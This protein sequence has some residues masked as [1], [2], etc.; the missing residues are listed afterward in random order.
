MSPVLFNQIMHFLSRH[1]EVLPLEEICFNRPETKKP[2]VAITFDDGYRDYLDYALPT[3]KKYGFHSSMFVVTDCV[4]N[5]T[6]TWTYVMD[7]V[8]F[9]TK[10]LEIPR[11]NYG[12]GYEAFELFKWRNKEEQLAYCRKFKQALKKMD[13]AEREKII[14]YFRECFD[15]AAVPG[16]IMMSWDDLR[17]LKNEPVEIGS[18]SISHPPLATIENETLLEHEIRK[19]G[20]IIQSQLG[21]FPV[22]ISYPVGSY[23]RR[24][25]ETAKRSGYKIGLALRQKKFNPDKDDLFEVPRLELYNDSFFR[26]V[27][28]LYGIETAIKSLIRR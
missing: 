19:S 11:R 20:E 28:K 12:K 6:P 4:D 15:D 8:F 25:M 5:N 18:H 16:N 14:K 3:L 27:I 2:Q 17:S 9:N 23:D 26:N 13:N 7:T 10:R 1:F 24:V 22:T 21:Y